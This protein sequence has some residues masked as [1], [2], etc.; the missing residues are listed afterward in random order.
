MYRQHIPSGKDENRR[1]ER[2]DVSGKLVIDRALCSVNIK[3]WDHSYVEVELE[4]TGERADAIKFDVDGDT[5]TITDKFK[6]TSITT[7]GVTIVGD[8]MRMNNIHAS[9]NIVISGSS[10]GNIVVA[11]GKVTIDG[12]EVTGGGKA[13]PT[14][15]VTVWMPRQCNLDIQSCI[16]DVTVDDFDGHLDCDVSASGD[17]GCGKVKSATIVISGSGDVSVSEVAEG[18]IDATLSGSGDVSISRGKVGKLRIH[19]SGSG[20][21][22]YRGSA[23]DAELRTSGSGDITVAEVENTLKQRATGSGDIRVKREPKK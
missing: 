20:D 17:I 9:G 15:K 22:V 1:T 14:P 16:A 3:A 18:P 12:K 2:F 11:G 21:A 13:E 7:S 8:G 19:T 6:G 4:M 10:I 5:L 23:K